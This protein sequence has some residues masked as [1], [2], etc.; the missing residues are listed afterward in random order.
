MEKTP[1]ATDPQLAA[2]KAVIVR[3]FHEVL[4]QK[5]LDIMPELLH[6]DVVLHRPGFDVIGLEA[7]MTRL[8]GT[9]Q[10]SVAFASEVTGVV[11]E[12]DMVCV[13][14]QHRTR[15]KPHT[16][17]S[18]AGEIVVREEQDLSWTAIVQFRLRDGRI[19]EEWVMRDELGMLMQLG[20]VS[21]TPR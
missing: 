17:R 20:A 12:G 7:A 14:I 9:F 6:E 21:V 18:R 10:D 15:A 3:Y 11:A 2:N 13:R 19:A 4:D 8:R 16:F 1:D 5:R